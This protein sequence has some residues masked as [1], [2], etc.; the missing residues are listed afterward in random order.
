MYQSYRNEEIT[1]NPR[2][3]RVNGIEDFVSKRCRFSRGANIVTDS[4]YDRYVRFCIKNKIKYSNFN[5]FAR[6]FR[7]AI[8][9]DEN[10]SIAG[11][12]IMAI[13]HICYK[14]DVGYVNRPG[15]SYVN[16]VVDD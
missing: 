7:Y 6:A 12:S 10:L 8:F 9:Y 3:T 5:A 14:E 1:N 4:I 15:W 11:V 13:N 16:L 2:K